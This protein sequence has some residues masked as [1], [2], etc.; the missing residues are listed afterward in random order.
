MTDQEM[1]RDL[2]ELRD[3]VEYMVQARGEGR[4]DTLLLRDLLARLE[5]AE[6][7]RHKHDH[8]RRYWRRRYQ[9]MHNRAKVAEVRAEAAEAKIAAIRAQHRVDKYTEGRATKY[10][11]CEEEWPCS[12]FQTLH[13]SEGK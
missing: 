5:A 11:I 3:R 12:T 10:C 1:L 9:S 13:E 8:D 6:Q 4:S 2:D 7:E